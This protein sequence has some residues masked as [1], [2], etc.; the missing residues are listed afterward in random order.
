MRG[1]ALTARSDDG[2]R[3]GMNCGRIGAVV[4]R[5]VG[6]SLVLLVMG[7]GMSGCWGGGGIRDDATADWPP[8]RLSQAE[9]R[10]VV[11]V[12]APSPGWTIEFDKSEKISGGYRVLLTVRRPDPA[13][14]YPQRTV[15]QNVITDVRAGTS[16]RVYRRLAEHD[17]RKPE[18]A[19]V[20]VRTDG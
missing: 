3:L 10:V 17:E 18:G 5:S 7:G 12:E 9:G 1:R 6:L 8:M 19:Y 2:D 14:F 11:V 15:E 16:V 13:F 20:L 4:V